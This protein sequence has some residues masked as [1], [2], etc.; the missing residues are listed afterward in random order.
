MRGVPRT[1]WLA[2]LAL[3]IGIVLVFVL[4]R[5]AVD[6]PNLEQ[7]ELPGTDSPDRQ[8][9]LHP[10]LAY[11][12][13]GLGTIYLIGAPLQLWRPFRE[14]HYPLHR[15]LGRV[16]ITVALISGC[17][18]IVFGVRYA[19]GGAAEGAASVVFGTWFL[20][21]VSLAFRA[22][23]RGDVVAHRRW[24][25][26]AFMI[27]LAVGTIR[28]WIGL[29][30]VSGLLTFPDRFAVAFWVGFAMHVALGEWWLA[31]NPHPED[32]PQPEPAEAQQT[33]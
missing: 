15:R 13:I 11:L 29:F 12:H 4:R 17:T 2:G 33:A 21:S 24:M 26:R 1:R 14:R 18:G 23:R 25:I 5:V 27:G 8:Y 6:I 32:H 31:T 20:L 28:I 16:L 10:S 9:V 30:S 3:L 7:G 22:I 19:F